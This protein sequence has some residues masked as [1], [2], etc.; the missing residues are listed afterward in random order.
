MADKTF[1]FT[2]EEI[3]TMG[4]VLIALVSLIHVTVTSLYIV[5]PIISFLILGLLIKQIKSIQK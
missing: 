1:E 4:L 3:S 5:I 2:N